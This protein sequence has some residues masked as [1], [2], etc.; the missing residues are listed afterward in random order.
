[1]IMYLASAFRRRDEIR[2]YKNRLEDAGHV[3]TS[4]WLGDTHH[5][6]SGELGSEPENEARWALE[7][8][9]DVHR[10]DVLVSFTSPEYGRGGRHVEYGLGIAFQKSLIIVGPKE[11]VFH[12]VPDVEHFSDPESFLA[13][14][15]KKNGA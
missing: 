14:Y 3:I 8:I 11:H 5:E 4:R 10:A 6:I 9:E 15:A 1:V 12:M 13:H 2:V 7:D